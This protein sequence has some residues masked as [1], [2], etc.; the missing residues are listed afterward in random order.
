MFGIEKN[1]LNN[2]PQPRVALAARRRFVLSALSVGVAGVIGLL[3]PLRA[4]AKWPKTLFEQAD[5][6][7]T[8]DALT[9]GREVKKL[10]MLKA[11]K[12]AENGGQVRIAVLIKE[13]PAKIKKVSLIV[14]KNP[15][16]LT[17][18]FVLHDNAEP[19]VSVN[20]KVRE[21]SRIVAL[22]EA[23]EGIYKDEV[24]VQVSAGGCG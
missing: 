11:P 16:P 13:P 23:D 10:A 1:E 7:K 4:W 17:S 6:G 3:T 19:N 21:T 20:L 15:V 8:I 18:Q 2:R 9:Q 22:A 5:Y 24:E 12:I 14:E